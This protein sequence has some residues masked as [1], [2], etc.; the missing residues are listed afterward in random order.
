MKHVDWWRLLPWEAISLAA[1]VALA[2]VVARPEERREF[3]TV[4]LITWAVVF[5]ALVGVGGW[6]SGAWTL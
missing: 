6:L 4:A 3:M 2:L 5:L 1:L